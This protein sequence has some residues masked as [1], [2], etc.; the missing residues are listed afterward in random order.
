MLGIDHQHG[1]RRITEPGDPGVSGGEPRGAS[2]IPQPRGND[3]GWMNRMFRQPDYGGLNREGKGLVR[4]YRAKM[5][6]LSRAQ[7]SRYTRA[8]VEM[9][10]AVDESHETLGGPATRKILQRELHDFGVDV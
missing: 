4:L 8:D 5:T 1:R 10:A 2:P 7:V 9:L 6:G 3:A